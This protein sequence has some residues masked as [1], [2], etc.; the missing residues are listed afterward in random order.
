MLGKK[1]L[2]VDADPQANLSAGLGTFSVKKSLAAVMK[3]EEDVYK[4]IVQV[5][6]N[7]DLVPSGNDLANAEMELSNEAGREFLLKESLDP[8]KSSYD[9]ILIDCP[10]SLG[11]LVLNA[12]TFAD[13][14][15]IP[16][17]TE[18]YATQGTAKLL[19]TFSAVKKR[20]NKSLKLL[21]I[22]P[23]MH[24]SRKNLNNDVLKSLEENF[25][26]HLMKSQIREN[27]ALAEAPIHGMSIFEYRPGSPGAKDYMSLAKEV[28]NK[29]E[30]EK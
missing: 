9:F 27:V 5:R 24:D 6:P 11:L 23:A 10:P 29:T 12:F 26:D 8:I 21:G 14:I 18:Y 25:P 20:L 28:I 22:L 19:D 7:L 16:I 15:L 17:Q 13:F 2:L 1:V 30:G 4:V 3:G